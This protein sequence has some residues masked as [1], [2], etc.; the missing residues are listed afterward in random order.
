MSA[1]TQQ[2]L[3]GAL[4]VYRETRGEYLLLAR[5][6]K[7]KKEFDIM[8]RFLEIANVYHGGVIAYKQA[9]REQPATR[10]DFASANRLHDEL[11]FE[12]A[13]ADD[14]V[15]LH[16]LKQRGLAHNATGAA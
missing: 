13:V 1:N 8:R 10:L 7:H 12:D 16:E 14:L 9:L 2:I 15:P 6:A 4:E 5:D 11:E 3:R